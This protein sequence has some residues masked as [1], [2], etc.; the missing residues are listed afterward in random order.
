MQTAPTQPTSQAFVPPRDLIVG[1]PGSPIASGADPRFAQYKVIRRNGKVTSFDGNKIRVALT[2]ADS[3]L[4]A[5]V[6][7]RFVG[8]A[9]QPESDAPL[10][11]NA[12]LVQAI[13]THGEQVFGEKIPA[14]GTP[15]YTD[16]RL[17]G[18][19]GIPA[20]IYGAG[21]RTVLESNAKR[22]DEHLALA[23]LHGATRVVARSL[24]ELLTQSD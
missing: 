18:A 12:P 13:Q 22:A 21:P 14:L 10:P 19:H 24:H 15:L 9:V 1:E 4:S 5:T 17:F 8:G 23:D 11:G 2:K 6:S 3:D 20:A 16:V 7:L